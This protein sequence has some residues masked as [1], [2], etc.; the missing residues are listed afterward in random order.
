MTSSAMAAAKSGKSSTSSLTRVCI[1]NLPPSFDEAKVQE[2]LLK[3]SKLALVITDVKVLRKKSKKQQQQQQQQHGGRSRQVAFCGFQSFEMANH[4]V[5]YFHQAYAGTTKLTVEFAKRKKDVTKK[6]DKNSSPSNKG[7]PFSPKQDEE[8]KRHRNQ[9]QALNLVVETA[10]T[11]KKGKFWDNDDDELTTGITSINEKA[12]QTNGMDVDD[13]DDGEEEDAVQAKEENTDT[14][15]QGNTTT[16]NNN[17]ASS[18]LD[19][20]KAITSNKAELADVDND[21]QDKPSIQTD[22][23]NNNI[24][25]KSRHPSKQTDSDTS[26]DAESTRGNDGRDQQQQQQQQQDDDNDNAARLTSNRLFLRNLPFAASEEDVKE[27][28]ASSLGENHRVLECHIP[29]DQHKRNKGFAFVRMETIA[30]AQRVLHELDDTDFQGRLLHILPAREETTNNN[31][32]S[33][34]G[35]VSFKEQQDLTRRKQALQATAG[36]SASFVRGDAV[37]D[38]LADR[39]GLRKGDI[40]NVKDGL[41][42]GDAAVRLALGETQIIEE[43]R[44]YFQDHGIDMEALVS[45]VGGR[46]GGGDDDD[47]KETELRRSNKAL[48]VKNLPY[49]TSE[50]ELAK[51]FGGVGVTPQRIL[52]PPS[53]TIALVEYGHP[54]DAR[55]AFK[56]LAYKRF[57]HVPVYLEW[58]PLASIATANNNSPPP[59]T[60]TNSESAIQTLDGG[61]NANNDDEEVEPGTSN[62]IYVKNLNFNTTEDT[63]HEFF[64]R[65]VRVRAVRIP[66][67]TATT[68]RGN[69]DG[70]SAQLSMGYGFVECDSEL[71]AS[72]AIKAL[73]GKVLEGHALQLQRSTTKA[74][75]S[76]NG[77]KRSKTKKEPTKIM[78]RNVPFQATRKELLQLFGSYGQL[79]KVRLPKKFDGSHRGFAFVEFLTGKEALSAMTVLSRTHLY[80][81]HLVLEWADDDSNDENIEWLRSKVQRDVESHERVQ[82]KR[83]K[84]Q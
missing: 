33:S 64:S 49:D 27:Y 78:V 24:I 28:L 44:K 39:L 3:E 75:A 13:V 53:R 23:N 16:T 56:R 43:N 74:Q 21:A 73:Q 80:G 15:E 47:D 5:Q 71:S 29:V 82:N 52:L 58:A 65:H 68:K 76:S 63:L 70:D 59:P 17:I 26:S 8:V 22:N 67:K 9:H 45:L 37:V 51:L 7:G 6:P 20:L 48:L 10:A 2:Y 83:I 72:K 41:S 42:S 36:W 77:A 19:F 25:I 30:Q 1:K 18:D 14:P 62:S 46:G 57:K 32:S 61:T 69:V 55:R 79:K 66:V 84:F 50:E 40:L 31:L 4:V 34:N 38:N 12:Q 11:S 35:H 54:T 60:T 81:R